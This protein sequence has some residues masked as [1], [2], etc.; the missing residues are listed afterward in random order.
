[1]GGLGS[2]L[3]TSRRSPLPSAG[4]SGTAFEESSGLALRERPLGPC[5][6]HPQ[7][8]ETARWVSLGQ[9]CVLLALLA[10]HCNEMVPVTEV[11]RSSGIISLTLSLG[12]YCWGRSEGRGG[13]GF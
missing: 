12:K 13:R 2:P 11:K 1:M 4:H 10:G 5:S 8:C 9:T 7:S 6:P 3:K